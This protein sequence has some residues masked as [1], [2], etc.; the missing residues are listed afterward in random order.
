MKDSYEKTNEFKNA[1]T[2]LSANFILMLSFL[3]ILCRLFLLFTLDIHIRN[4]VLFFS[5]DISVILKK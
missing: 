1:D 5:I 4:I 3:F 2:H